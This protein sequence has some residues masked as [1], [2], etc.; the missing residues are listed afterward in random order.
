M[1][2]IKMVIEIGKKMRKEVVWLIEMEK[3]GRQKNGS[4]F[5]RTLKLAQCSSVENVFFF[6]SEISFAL[7]FISLSLIF[8][9]LSLSI[10]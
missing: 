9:S 2:C 3:G 4:L 6:H 5:N 10:S 7:L 1:A 8:S